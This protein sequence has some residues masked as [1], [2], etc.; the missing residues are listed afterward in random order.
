VSLALEI[1]CGGLPVVDCQIDDN[2]RKQQK[3]IHS[4]HALLPTTRR[5]ILWRLLYPNKYVRRTSRNVVK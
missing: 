5:I 2:D 3:L 4:E 1:L